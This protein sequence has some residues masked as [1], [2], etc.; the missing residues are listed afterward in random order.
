[1]QVGAHVGTFAV[2]PR[3]RCCQQLAGIT[4]R[5]APREHGA[6]IL[7]HTSPPA[8][9]P[10]ARPPQDGSALFVTV[11]RY[12]TPAGTE[13]DSVGIAP[14]SACSVLGDSNGG[15]GS[16]FA[17]GEDFSRVAAWC[18]AWVSSDAPKPLAALPGPWLWARPAASPVQLDKGCCNCLTLSPLSPLDTAMPSMPPSPGLPVGVGSGEALQESLMH[19][20]CVLTARSVLGQQVAVVANAAQ[21]AQGIVQPALP[22]ER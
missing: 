14:D 17:A 1:M 22:R 15:N 9:L 16:A 12:Q 19:D 3:W 10:P 2:T 18:A 4:H 5:L 13:I 6:G 7:T 8:P 11:A 20:S 21:V